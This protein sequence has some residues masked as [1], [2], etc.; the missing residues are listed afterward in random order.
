M[1]ANTYRGSCHCGKVSY[2][3]TLDLDAP[4]ITCNCSIC[5]RTGTMLSFVPIDRF[6][7]HTGE[8]A[9]TDYQFGR[10]NIHHYFCAT[11]GVRSFARGSMPD[12]SPIAAINVRCLENV[13]LHDLKVQQFD[14]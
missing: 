2:E 7:L 5:Q 6:K 10:K 11:C 13:E 3:V 1:A 8:D 9:V 14:G 12:G 4:V